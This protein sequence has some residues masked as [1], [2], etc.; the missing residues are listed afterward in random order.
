LGGPFLLATTLWERCIYLW[1]SGRLAVQ[2]PVQTMV[3]TRVCTQRTVRCH[4]PSTHESH[5]QG[6]RE[7]PRMLK[8]AP[9][10]FAS[11]GAGIA[12][13]SA[14]QS[15]WPHSPCGPFPARPGPWIKPRINRVT[16]LIH[17]YFL[18]KVFNLWRKPIGECAQ[19]PTQFR[20]G[21]RWRK[22]PLLRPRKRTHQPGQITCWALHQSWRKYV[23]MPAGYELSFRPSPQL[24]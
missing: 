23:R 21:C 2:L 11:Q 8:G 1:V 18:T 20:Q 13:H 9:C 10:A 6:F 14:T 24:R 7:A 19:V 3:Q 5:R 12:C 22:F 15:R 4:L 16:Q 17:G